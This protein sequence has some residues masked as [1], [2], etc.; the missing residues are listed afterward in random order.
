MK[1][2]FLLIFFLPLICFSQTNFPQEIKQVDSVSLSKD[3]IYNKVHDY[4][5]ES[6][7]AHP[8]VSDKEA[9]KIA[10]KDYFIVNAGGSFDSIFFHYAIDIKDNKYRVTLSNFYHF[11]TGA[12]SCTGGNLYEEKPQC[13]YFWMPKKRWTSIKDFALK[14]SNEWIASVEKQVNKEDNF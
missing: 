10:G 13:G 12:A 2:I 1:N 11:C 5:S 14:Q 6:K 4:F 3:I 7:Y 8:Q 9:G